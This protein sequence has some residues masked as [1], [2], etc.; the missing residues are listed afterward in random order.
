MS[1]LDMQDIR[2]T[3]GS[4]EA[5][6]VALDHASLTVH[7]DELVALVGPSGSGKTTLLSIAGGLLSPTGGSVV[8]GPHHIS[9]TAAGSSRGSGGTTWGSSSRVQ[10]RAVPDRQGEPLV[11]ADVAGKGGKDTTGGPTSC[12]RSSASATGRRTR[13]RSCRAAS[14]SGSRSVGP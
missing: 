14:A 9:T 2:K 7:D 8:V 13:R 12:S 3:Y 1:A 5:E 4:G 6:V 10:P 11:V